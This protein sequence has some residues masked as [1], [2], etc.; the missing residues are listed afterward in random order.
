MMKKPKANEA[1][2][3]RGHDDNG[4]VRHMLQSCAAINITPPDRT[5]P[6]LGTDVELCHVARLL[7]L[8]LRETLLSDG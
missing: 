5:I 1:Q 3:K 4:G 7:Y 2:Q 8:R 6:M